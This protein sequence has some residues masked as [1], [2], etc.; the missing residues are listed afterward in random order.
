MWKTLCNDGGPD[1]G[2]RKITSAM[3]VAG[4]CIV[5]VE[6][7]RVSLALTFI[8][9]AKLVDDGKGGHKLV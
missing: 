8:P 7:E 3:E 1:S 4:G 6:K 2:F 5:Q 9:K